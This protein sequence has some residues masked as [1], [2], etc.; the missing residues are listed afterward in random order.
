MTDALEAL[1]LRPGDT[2][3]VR[4]RPEYTHEEFSHLKGG[5]EAELPGVR[6][7][8]VAADQ[9]AAYRPEVGADD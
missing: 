8:V 9:I 5:I 3:I 2:L 1:A 4:V 6:V 7:V